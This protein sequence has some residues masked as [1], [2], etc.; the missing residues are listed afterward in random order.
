MATLRDLT[1]TTIENDSGAG[2]AAT[3]LTGGVWDASELDREGIDLNDVTDPN[4]RIK[5]FLVIRWRTTIP[6]G[7]EVLPAESRFVEFYIYQ[8]LGQATIDSVIARLKVLF[9]R[10]FFTATGFGLVH[11]LWAGDLGEQ[12]DDQ[13]AM[14]AMNRSRYQINDLRK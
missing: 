8:H 6:F 3:L 2:G 12:S 1:R 4:G 13:M 7:P 11:F 5:P 10:K 9:H 14:A